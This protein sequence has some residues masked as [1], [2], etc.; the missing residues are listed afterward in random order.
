M[1]KYR[2]D[3]DYEKVYIYDNS[4]NAYVF[5]G[6]YFAFGLQWTMTDTTMISIVDSEGY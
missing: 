5:I 2:F 4:A 3:D 6:S 1:E